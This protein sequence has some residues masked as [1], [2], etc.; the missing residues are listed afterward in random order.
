VRIS[1]FFDVQADLLQVN[2]YNVE[3]NRLDLTSTE[4]K[5]ISKKQLKVAEDFR[6]I[7]KKIA[8]DGNQAEKSA[9]KDIKA[10]NEK[11]YKA[12]DIMDELPDSAASSSSLF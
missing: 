5:N 1:E 7:A 11:K 3:N 4:R 6:K 12:S 8:V 2:A 10:E 9:S